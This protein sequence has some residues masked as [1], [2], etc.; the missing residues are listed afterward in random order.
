M[1]FA[2]PCVVAAGLVSA[3]VDIKSINRASPTRTVP[4][5]YIVELSKGSHF[6]R[7]FVSPHEELYHDLG[8]RGASWEVTRE[9]SDNILTG[10][11]VRLGSNADLVKL[12]DAT[13]VEYIAP[14]YLHRGPK[15]IFQQVMQVA[16]NGTA[17]NYHG[18][19]STHAM[20]GVDKLHAESYFGQGIKIGIIDTGIDYTH[21]SLGGAIGPGNKIIGGYDFVGDAYTG[22]QDSIPMPDPDPLDQCNGHG[23]HVAGIIGANPNNPWNISGVAYQSEINAYRVLGCDGSTPDDIVIAALLRAHADGNDVINLSLGEPNGWAESLSSVVASRIAREGR[24]VTIAAGNDGEYGAWYASSPA[25]GLDVISVGSIDNTILYQQN[26]T[27]SNGRDIPYQSFDALN[28]PGGLQLYATSPDVKTTADAC[29]PLPVN[30]PDLSNRLVIIRRGTCPFLTKI[31]NIAAKGGRYFL[32]YDNIDQPLIPISTGNYSGALIS[33]A[34]GV[35]LVQQAIPQN[36]TV[37]FPNTPYIIS[38]PTGGLVSPFSSYGPSY[39]MHLKPAIVA[40]GD[41]I[42]STWPVRMGSWALAS[43]TSMA[44]P[45][46]AGAAAILLQ[47]HGKNVTTSQAA[48]SIF[49]NTAMP[50]MRTVN[51]S[52]VPTTGQQGAGLLNVYQAVKATG[53]LLPAEI[54]LNDTGYFQGT[55]TLVVHNGGRQDITYRLTHLSAGTMNTINGIQSNLGPIDLINNSATVT[56]EPAEAIVPA[57]SS[58]SINITISPPTSLDATQFPVYSGYI[59]A[60]GSDNSTLQSTYI[61]VAATLKDMKVI[62]DTNAYFGDV[63][64]PVVV[65]ALGDPVPANGSAIFSMNVLDYPVIICRLVAGS[66]LARFDLIDSQQNLTTNQRRTKH[67]DKNHDN[68]PQTT[69]FK[70]STWSWLFTNRFQTTGSFSAVPTLGTLSQERYIPRNSAA[71]TAEESGYYVVP[72]NQYANGTAIPNGTYRIL[73][74]VLKITGNPDQEEDYETWTSPTIVVS[75]G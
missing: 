6:K 32:V 34:D 30:T 39:D 44:S 62:D 46:V 10:A 53:S 1:K 43:G 49:Q 15:P 59:R 17:S 31:N 37:S 61:G 66:A 56:I 40:P 42:P 33:Q 64:V 12:A 27:L 41:S 60:I 16:P 3:A 5:S 70:R 58:A 8:R 65:N 23:T 2:I 54:L 50:V 35:F 74:R 28:I 14:I 63:Q 21:P 9:Y 45:F 25:T 7:G 52:L 68:G 57:G 36:L 47:T 4:N 51:T 18:P 48:R 29:E 72:I 67:E 26:A 71:T 24:I 13:G 69:P 11:A 22:L 75:R 55:H 20:T 73:L 19:F 38:N